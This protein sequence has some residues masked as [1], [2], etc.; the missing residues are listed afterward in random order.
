MLWHLGSCVARFFFAV[1]IKV[2][3]RNSAILAAKRAKYREITSENQR[4]NTQ[5]TSKNSRKIDKKS[6][7]NA[8]NA[9]FC[10]RHMSVACNTPAHR[11]AENPHFSSRPC[12]SSGNMLF[13]RVDGAVAPKG[14]TLACFTHFFALR[15][16]SGPGL[17][18]NEVNPLRE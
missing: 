9:R 3:F 13:E 14:N 17:G 18:A 2:N 5:K 12:C 6:E 11:T 8:K 15:Q 10:A 1:A 7:K 16:T 4:K